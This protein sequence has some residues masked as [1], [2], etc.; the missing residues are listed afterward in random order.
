MRREQIS[1]RIAYEAEL[2]RRGVPEQRRERIIEEFE[3]EGRMR[4]LAYERWFRAS[5]QPTP[6]VP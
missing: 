1:E 3:T 2:E 6:A 4:I 5:L